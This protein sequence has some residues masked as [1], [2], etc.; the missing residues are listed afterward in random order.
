MYISDCSQNITAQQGII[1]SPIY[2]NGTGEVSC[3]YNVDMTGNKDVVLLSTKDFSLPNGTLD[4]TFQNT[5]TPLTGRIC[6]KEFL[7]RYMYDVASLD[8]RSHGSSYQCLYC[9]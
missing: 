2:L 6:R 3:T 4:V 7:D 9:S 1:T 5:T 8:K